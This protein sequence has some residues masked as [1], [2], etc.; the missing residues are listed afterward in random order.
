MNQKTRLD[1]F[2]VRLVRD[3]AKYKERFVT[4]NVLVDRDGEPV[5]WAVD[6]KPAEGLTIPN[7]PPYT[8]SQQ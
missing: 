3:L 4:I 6:T 1:K 5:A 2:I 8:V 7:Q